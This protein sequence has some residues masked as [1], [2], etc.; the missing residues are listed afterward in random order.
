MWDVSLREILPLVLAAALLGALLWHALL[1]FLASRLH[2]ERGAF[3]V[4]KIAGDDGWAVELAR[5]AAPPRPEGAPRLP[6]VIVCHG[7]GANSISLDL[8]E[9]ISLPRYLRARGFDTWLLDLRGR[10][11]S[12][13]PPPGRGPYA[14]SFDDHARFDVKAA[15]ELVQKE[16]GAP[17]VAWVGHSMGGMALYAHAEIHGDAALQAAVLVGSPVGIAKPP[18]VA[19]NARWARR[20]RIERF[21]AGYQVLVARLAAPLAGYWTPRIARILLNPDNVAPR[22]QRVAMARGIANMSTAVVHQLA[23]WALDGELKSI[24]GSHVY[25]RELSKITIPV[26]AIGGTVDRLVPYENARL[27]LDRIGS[28]EKEWLLAGV[29]TGLSADYG[30]TDL[31]LGRRCKDEIFPR[32]AAFLERFP[33]ETPVPAQ[34]GEKTA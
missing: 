19:R 21:P 20:A 7:F 9:A 12:A 16:T 26:F 22:T 14:Y 13:H 8:A 24:D 28:R 1:L 2:P 18:K 30:H 6:P 11:G 23:D 17:R 29:S 34:S 4:Y 5:Y 3:E 25:F 10:G 27:A 33:L 31:L 15:I 32:I